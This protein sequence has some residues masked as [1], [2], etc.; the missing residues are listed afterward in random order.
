MTITPSNQNNSHITDAPTEW[1]IVCFACQ[2]DVF[3]F[4][5]SREASHLT[6]VH[7]E[8]HHAGRDEAFITPIDPSDL[9][10]VHTPLPGPRELPG[11]A[12]ATH[13]VV[14]TAGTSVPV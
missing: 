14:K 4:I 6:G 13:R 1:V 10:L 3:S 2:L 8:L 11:S 9:T 12:R 7:N 5:D